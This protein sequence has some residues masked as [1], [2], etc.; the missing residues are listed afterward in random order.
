MMASASHTVSFH[1]E[2]LLLGFATS[3]ASCHEGK[4]LV[5]WHCASL[6]TSFCGFLVGRW[7]CFAILLAWNTRSSDCHTTTR[8]GSR[9]T[10]AKVEMKLSRRGEVFGENGFDRP[11][12][13]YR[14]THELLSDWGSPAALISNF[15]DTARTSATV[16]IFAAWGRFADLTRC[17]SNALLTG[18]EAAQQRS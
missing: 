15:P 13:S 17:F 16:D 7:R 5:D 9:M 18:L 3:G 6:S 12:G 1:S 10:R 2:V 14:S 4:S 8:R 11:N